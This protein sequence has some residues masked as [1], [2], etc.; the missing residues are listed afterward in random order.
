MKIS[1][2]ISMIALMLVMLFA[3]LGEAREVTVS[4][5]DANRPHEYLLDDVLAGIQ[6]AMREW[7][8]HNASAALVFHWNGVINIENAASDLN[9]VVI[10]WVNTDYTSF[11]G[12]SCR[13]SA[14]CYAD[15]PPLPLNHI[16]LATYWTDP[17]AQTG[18]WNNPKHIPGAPTSEDLVGVLIHEFAHLFRNTG[19]IG[20]TSVLNGPTSITQ[21]YLFNSDIFGVD[22]TRYNGHLNSLQI[23]AVDGSNGTITTLRNSVPSY[24]IHSPASLSFCR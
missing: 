11:V 6:R 4:Y 1:T 7:E 5:V 15:S 19:E 17:L 9:N 13:L 16:V 14:G 20:P 24:H 2:R 12:R 10:R 18:R 23:F 22:H 21:R 3:R 8:A